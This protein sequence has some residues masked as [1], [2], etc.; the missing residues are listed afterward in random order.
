MKEA[1]V[2]A[3]EPINGHIVIKIDQSQVKKDL[4]LSEDSMIYIPQERAFA[5]ASSRGTVVK[6]AKDAFGQRYKERFGEDISAP[7][8]GD[9]IH[10]VPYQTAKMDDEG[11]YYLVTDDS[12]KFIERRVDK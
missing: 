12:I 10:F 2:L 5:G 11:L 7:V 6:M 9:I 4:G 8:V 3:G 1:E